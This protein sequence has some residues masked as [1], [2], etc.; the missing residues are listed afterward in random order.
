MTFT[1]R[2]IQGMYQ[3]VLTRNRRWR[4]RLQVFDLEG[5]GG[6]TKPRSASRPCWSYLSGSAD[7]EACNYM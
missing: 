3:G 5:L 4:C 7:S 1:C 6:R 2:N